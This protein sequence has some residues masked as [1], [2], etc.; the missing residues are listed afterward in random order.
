MAGPPPPTAAL[1]VLG[2]KHGDQ[3]LLEVEIFDHPTRDWTNVRIVGPGLIQRF[4][5]PTA[6]L[7]RRGSD[8]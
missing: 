7:R 5:V 1:D 2:L 4:W 6:L 8:L 3:A